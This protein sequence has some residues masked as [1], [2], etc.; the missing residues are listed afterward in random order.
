[1]KLWSNIAGNGIARKAFARDTQ[2][3]EIAE[4]AIVLPMV[5]MLLLGIYWFGRAYNTYATITHAA[6]EG[7]RAATA[8]T[9]ALCGNTALLP[10]QVAT[11]VSQ[12]LQASKLIPSQV[13][14]LLPNPLLKDCATGAPVA[15]C[16]A[17]GGGNPQI[18]FQSNVQ[19]NGNTTGPPACGVS[20]SFQYPY[21]F[22]L[23]FTSLNRQLILLKAD[24]QTT[25]ED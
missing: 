6:R 13:T 4:A 3:A 22:Y 10:D 18:C 8:Q 5:F 17:I 14:P 12:A 23:P 19:I 16:A 15:A 1:M 11:R 7:A 2:G 24:V 25:G 20:V 9:C 21:Q